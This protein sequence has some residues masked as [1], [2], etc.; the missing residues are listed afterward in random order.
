MS[1]DWSGLK[2]MFTSDHAP[3]P[4]R[5]GIQAFERFAQADGFVLASYLALN[6]LLSFVPFLLFLVTLAGLVGS[7]ENGTFVVAFIFEHLPDDVADVFELALADIF[8]RRES[9]LLTISTFTI[10]WT[11]GS[12]LEGLRK[13]LNRA[14]GVDGTIPYWRRRLQST[15]MVIGL[16]L[17]FVLVALSLLIAPFAWDWL[18]ESFR[19]SR[20]IDLF[21]TGLRYAVGAVGLL[22][23]IV[24]LYRYLPNKRLSWTGVCPGAVLVVVA[25]IIGSFLYSSYMSELTDYTLV[26]GNLGGI[27]VTLI[28]FWAVGVLVVF[29]AQLNA[30]IEEMRPPVGPAL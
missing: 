1:I 5:C 14:Y 3:L 20:S 27:I 8:Q 30:V 6:G 22:A 4:I 11:T 12:G 25:L 13:A 19:F 2:S 7:T 16:S 15:A 9:E 26:F 18:Q 23:I 17:I 21:A 28:F 24:L 29:G 10:V